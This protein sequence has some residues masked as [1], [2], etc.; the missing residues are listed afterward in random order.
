MEEHVMCN[1][2]GRLGGGAGDLR[3]VRLLSCAIRWTPEG[4]HYKAGPGHP[5]L[6]IRDLLA[7]RAGVKA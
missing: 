6:L 4:L 1:V 2:E 5:E 7:P 3:A